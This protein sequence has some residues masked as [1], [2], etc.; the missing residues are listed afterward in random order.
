MEF[1]KYNPNDLPIEELPV[2]YG[3]NNG[4]QT[5]FLYAQLISSDGID[6]GSHLC[7]SESFM[8]G[9]L[10]CLVGTAPHRHEG[11]VKQYPD[12]Y[13]MEFVYSD[14]MDNHQKFIDALKLAND[15]NKASEEA[16]HASVTVTWSE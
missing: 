3:F 4:G 5:N 16:E 1:A 15:L 8:P 14:D 10:G 11:F 6:M 7:S 2:I 9:D 13:R 12:G